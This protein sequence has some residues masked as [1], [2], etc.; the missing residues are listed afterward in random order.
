MIRLFATSGRRGSLRTRY[1]AVAALFVLFLLAAAWV[2]GIQVG[3]TVHRA[4]G[5]TE[6]RHQARQILHRLVGSIWES[7]DHLY[8]FL[9]APEAARA[10]RLQDDLNTA[11]ALS[12]E[13]AASPWI[14]DSTT[15]PNDVETLATTLEELKG[16]TERL[17]AVRVD[18]EKLLPAMP[19]MVNHMLPANDSFYTAATLAMDEADE[20]R[21]QNDQTEIYRLFADSRH[22]WTLMIGAFRT[23]VSNRFFIFGEPEASM[24]AQAANIALYAEGVERLLAQLSALDK[25]HALEFQQSESL[26][27]MLGLSR[28]WQRRYREVQAIMQSERWR[29][30][31]P[32]LHEVIHPLFTRVHE[33]TDRLQ[34]A[35]DAFSIQDM[36]ALSRIAD[37]LSHTLW[38]L[39]LIGIAVTAGGYLLFEHTVRRPVATVAAALKAEAQGASDV[40][41]LDTTTSE[42]HD[43]IEAFG[44]M[45]DQVH[46]RQQRLETILDNA[47]EGILTF[48][49]HGH[50]ESCNH[51]AE[52]LFGYSEQELIGKTLALLIPPPD[53]RHQRHGYLEHFMRTE[54]RRLIGHEGEMI[55][56]R[57]DG[58]TFQ[59]AIKISRIELQG[60]PL[61]TGLVADISERKALMEHLKAMAEHDGLTGL[62]NRSFFQDELERVVARAARGG[63]Q[64]HALLYIDL[65]N[66]KYINDTL[67]HA[68]G[69][70]LLIEV[71]S[72]LN[73]RA[74]K[75]DLI[76][77]LGGD[78]FTVLLYNTGQDQSG[79]VAESFRTALSSYQFRH[80]QERVDIGCSIG[81]APIGAGAGT[82][83]EVLSRAD[84]A[85]HLA[86]RSGRNRVHVF[87]NADEQ[88]V[89][90]MAIDMGWSRRIKEAIEH[91]RFALACQPIVRVADGEIEAYEVLIR[92]QGEHDD[93][94]LPGGFLP[95]AE[96]FGLAVEIDK[97]VVRNAIE[98]L[99]IQRRRLPQLRYSINLSGQTLTDHGVCDLIL[100]WLEKTGVDPA[101]LTFEVTETVAIADMTRAESFLSRLQQIGCRTALDDFGSGLSSFAYLKDLPVNEI[102]I[103][104]RFVR[105][106]ATSPVDQAVV[107]AMNDIA[108]ALGKR[109]VAEF[110]ENADSLRL[111]AEYG[112]DYAQGYHL[113]R[114]DVVLPCKAIAEHAG[115]R[116][117]CGS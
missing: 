107:K 75:S 82:A 83:E 116:T 14:A 11:L 108:H 41:I 7:E 9:L 96:R 59:L 29:T 89:A 79:Q 55:G 21:S 26:A 51:A 43:L 106:L 86:K 38:L 49:E 97:W 15:L 35:I 81:V 33:S 73:K 92:L 18:V 117:M 47:A 93:L 105:N 4:A 44:H 62:Y 67:G 90:T 61:Y 65:D 12:R 115:D 50:I 6:V 88:H 45:R 56:R 77:R 71:A 66:F 32:M 102:K 104:G 19:V 63:Q 2:G 30:D 68:A 78:E 22:T 94:I 40:V 72:I 100:A 34:T 48:D 58:E 110:V 85:C 16:Q 101:A 84:F 60:R 53:S 24:R 91:G 98:T 109:T 69:D 5:N 37:E 10:K 36:G 20:R 70:K 111:L 3:D 52:K 95:S 54:I 8:N 113:G 28:E 80:G 99:A 87:S 46:S 31:L 76:A 42:T 114:P 57:K 64:G 74:R 27:S 1:L 39:A 23:W 25:R 17:L 13:L 103:D 112:V